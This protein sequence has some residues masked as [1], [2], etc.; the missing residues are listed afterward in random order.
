[1]VLARL[2]IAV[3]LFSS[4]LSGIAPSSLLAAQEI[5]HLDRAQGSTE[6]IVGGQPF[7]ILGGELGNSSAGTAA[8]A[9]QILP[10]LARAHINTVLMP[11]AW[12]QLE[13][14]EGSFDFAILDHWIEQA[15]LQ[16]LHLV[17]L[18]FGSWKNAFSSY[19]PE[20]VK[21]DPRRF[22]RAISPD[23]RPMEILSTFSKE[24]LDADARAFRALM[25]H[26][27][28]SDATQQTVL[29]VQVENE[30]GILGSAR[31]HSAEADRLFSGPVPEALIQDLRTHPNWWPQELNRTWNLDGHTWRGVFGDSSAEVFMAWNYARYIGQVA[32]AGKA[33]YPLPMYANAQL[34]APQERAGE[35][36]SGG[37]YPLN[38]ELYR[39]AAPSLDFFSP[40]IY[41]PNFEYWLERY[42]DRDNPL[43]IPEARSDA[44]PFNAFCAYGDRAFGF[45]PFAVDSLPDVEEGS[46]AQSSKNPL[47]Q[48]YAV[49]QQLE[50]IVPQAQREGRTRGLVLHVS[51]PRPLQTVSLGGYLFTATLARSW[52][53]RNLLQDDGAMIVV[54]TAPDEFLIAGTSL[55]INVSMDPDVKEG[56][57]GIASV[58][59]GSRMQG[60]WVAAQRLNG[61]QDN[62]GRSISLPDHRFALLRVKLYTIP[63]R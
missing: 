14:V 59:A 46:D 7:L 9:D 42:S 41:W 48:A 35:Y 56:V 49:L 36:P 12:E 38:L 27:K 1:M 25:R 3:F 39:V 10:R 16:H 17:L 8:Q 13:P 2:S 51:S 32:A 24:N 54:Q 45:S 61:D 58:E 60:K 23:G 52:P 19:A 55:S 53:A 40:D 63:S 20:W 15:R 37:P 47:A 31:D 33:E 28:E 50:D 22:S 11:V 43:F 6:L 21:N 44:G 26:L 34:P 62:Q 57:A 5:P 18:W 4:L 30:V 29:M